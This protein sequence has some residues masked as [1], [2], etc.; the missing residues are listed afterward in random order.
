MGWAS[1]G[2]VP[3][4]ARKRLVVYD[5]QGRRLATLGDS[6]DDFD[7]LVSL[8]RHYVA[9]HSG[10]AAKQIQAKKSR[11]T[12]LVS[13]ATGVFLSIAAIFAAWDTRDHQQMA[14][15][16]ADEGIAGRAEIV[17]RF[18]A[19]NGVTCRVE[20][21]VTTPDGRSSTRNAEVARSYWQSLEGETHVPIVYVP[22]KPQYSRLAFGEVASRQMVDQPVFGYGLAVLGA[23]LALVCLAGGVM[24]WK[25]WDLHYDSNTRRWSVQRFGESAR[26]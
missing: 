18:V 5:K 26:G 14:R 11:R 22:D 2:D 9:Q 13:F 17:R 20:Y 24:L 8:V 21:R 23:G 10:T 25:G 1:L 7:Q 16:L 12:A 15:R 19:P 3:L 6:F 4:N